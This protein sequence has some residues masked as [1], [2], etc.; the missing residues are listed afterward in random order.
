MIL[1]LLVVVAAV[2]TV[3]VLATVVVV[4]IIV[5]VVAV[6]F[7]VVDTTREN[8]AVVNINGLSCQPFLLYPC[9]HAC[10]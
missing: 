10:M 1:F 4:A 2:A 8:S 7:A 9:M 3:V 6:A 5:T